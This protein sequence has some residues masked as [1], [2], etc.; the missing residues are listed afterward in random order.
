[1]MAFEQVKQ[2]LKQR[3]PVI[4]VD[5]VLEVRQGEYVKAVKN[6]TANEPYFQGHFPDY[7]I[8]PGALIIEA[9]AQAASILFSY[10]TGK[11]MSQDELM[12][13]GVVNDMRLLMPVY[14]GDVLI[15]EIAVIKILGT[16]AL[17][18]ATASVDG[19]V[20]AKGKLSF[21]QILQRKLR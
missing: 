11:G 1:M 14:P 13:L 20:A 17:V 2:Y 9:L 18:E 5:K 16:S 7:C 6:V 19:Q 15:L 8:M 21:A 12:V 10:S 3:Y 4:M